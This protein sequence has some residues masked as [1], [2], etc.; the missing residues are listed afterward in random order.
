MSHYTESEIAFIKENYPTLGATRCGR[1]LGRPAEVVRRLAKQ[2]GIQQ[3]NK[4]VKL[5][6]ER[7]VNPELFRNVTLPEVAYFLGYFWADGHIHTYRNER[8]NLTYHRIAIEV[9]KEDGDHL[10]K[11]AETFGKWAI[12]ERARKR[13]GVPMKPTLSLVINNAPLYGFLLDHGYNEK[14]TLSPTNILSHIPA[15]LRPA[16]WLGFF[17]GDGWVLEER[18]NIGFAGGYDQDWTDLMTLLNGMEARPSVHP[19]VSPKGHQSSSV[20]VQNRDGVKAFYDYVKPFSHLG[21]PRKQKRFEGL[22][23]TPG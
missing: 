9:Q 4:R 20:T 16:F 19:Y 2:W 12:V 23:R 7:N 17:D 13:Y 1:Q 18:T 22:F 5:D 6:H 11:V 15:E 14:S 3:V 10:R 21:L 8:R